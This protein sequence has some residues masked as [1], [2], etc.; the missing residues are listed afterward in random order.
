MCGERIQFDRGEGVKY[1]R[2]SRTIKIPGAAAGIGNIGRARQ[3]W[4]RLGVILRQ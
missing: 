3:V 4:G 1:N 2:R